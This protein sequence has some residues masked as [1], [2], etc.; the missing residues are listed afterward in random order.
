MR[1]TFRLQVAF[2]GTDF[3]GWQNQP[4]LRTV[5]GVIEHALRRTL[6]HEVDLIG[7]GRTDAGVHAAGHVS[8]F[9]TTCEMT[10]EQLRHSIGSR[11]PEDVSI[12]AV[13]PVHPE[14]HA[15]RDARSKLYRYRIHNAR[16]GAVEGLTQRCTYHFWESLDVEAM[17]AGGQHFIGEM[18]FT[19]MAATG[20]VRESMVRTVL[21]CD[22]ERHLDEIRIDVEGTGFLWKQVRNM[23]G[24][25]M[26]VGRGRWEP[27]RVA[28]ILA[29]HDR[30]NAGPTAPALGLCLQWVRYPPHLLS[31][32]AQADVGDAPSSEHPAE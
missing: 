19:A 21:R 30:A 9:T 12:T 3:H 1:R 17:R 31:C 26:N 22:V 29:T 14:F 25:L 32:P 2:D 13:R 20:G 6:R 28:E 24:T 15:T 8:N 4:G 5:Q 7:S 23:V 11:L 27:Q 10:P 18:D 16:R